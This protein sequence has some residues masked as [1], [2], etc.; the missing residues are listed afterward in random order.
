MTAI[1]TLRQREEELKALLQT[2]EGPAQLE[3]LASRYEGAGGGP[4]G[5]S[6]ITYILVY[7]RVAGL[8]RL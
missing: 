4:R 3:Q 5:P 1:K 2:P 7:E 6:V 8:I